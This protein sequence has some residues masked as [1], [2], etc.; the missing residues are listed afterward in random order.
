M[1]KALALALSK[2]EVYE[3]AFVHT[4]KRFMVQGLYIDCFPGICSWVPSNLP[5][6]D[7]SMVDIDKA[8]WSPLA[9]ARCLGTPYQQRNKNVYHLT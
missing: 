4:F 7:E 1:F 3:Y 2:K 9:I 5:A 8:I 6:K